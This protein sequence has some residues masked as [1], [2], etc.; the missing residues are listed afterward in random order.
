MPRDAL[1]AG[2][3]KTCAILCCVISILTPF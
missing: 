2:E 3:D 1:L